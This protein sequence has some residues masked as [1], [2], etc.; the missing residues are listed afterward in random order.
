[1]SN[2]NKINT[3]KK[4]IKGAIALK[5]AFLKGYFLAYKA[6]TTATCV[7]CLSSL[8]RK[9]IIH[10]ESLPCCKTRLADT[11]SCFSKNIASS[12]AD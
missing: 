11:S 1:M 5:Y 7:V 3:N 8:S 9:Q 4:I 2:N 12:L 10:E 6:Y